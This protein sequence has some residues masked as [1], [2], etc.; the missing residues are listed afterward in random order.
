MNDI[1]SLAIPP[2]TLLRLLQYASVHPE[3]GSAGE[4][5]ARVIEEWLARAENGK[6][7]RV[8]LHG[9]H[10]KS[11][12]LPEGT[13]LRA[14]NRVG[15]AYAEVIG[16]AIV[17]QGLPVSPHEFIC[18]CKGISRSAWAE[19]ALLFPAE[20]RWRRADDCRRE[21]RQVQPPPETAAT[22]I[23]TAMH[24]VPVAAL[25]ARHRLP[26]VLPIATQAEHQPLTRDGAAADRERIGFNDRRQGSRRQQD[27][28]L[29]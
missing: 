21:F 4:L 10:W 23:E 29:D 18:R 13:Q 26:R 16:D 1:A 24:A 28:L 2:D 15:F 14:W 5:A 25:A 8:R 9:Y 12:F 17:Y 19:V 22:P 3:A 7:G 11:L 27:L 6:P 20:Q